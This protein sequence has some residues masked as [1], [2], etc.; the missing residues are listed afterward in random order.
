MIKFTKVDK[1][2]KDGQKSLCNINLEIHQGEFVF[3][4][5][6][7]G[8]G[9]ST[10]LKLLLREELVTSG[11][12]TVLGQDISKINDNNIH[13]LRR[14]IGVIFQDFRLL[15]EKTAYEN[16]ELAMRVVGASPKDIK[17]RVLN[18]LKQ[19]GLVDKANRYPS[20]LSGGECQRVAIARAI[21]NKPSIIIADECTGN[22]DINN[23]IEIVNILDEINKNG[24]TVIMATHDIELLK[25]FKKRTV[26]LKNGQVTRD[27]KGENNE[28]DA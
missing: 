27:T 11:R 5:G 8:A 16:V 12:L 18:V 9:K 7:S 20:Q 2:Y 15:K 17:P 28:F 25:I 13:L 19:V 6:H 21:A 26:E 23:S 22:L 1:V 4:V 10:M 3:L 14:R 24:T